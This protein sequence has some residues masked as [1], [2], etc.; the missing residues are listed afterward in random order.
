M[1]KKFFLLISALLTITW[2]ASA[3]QVGVF[4][5]MAATGSQI[6]KDGN[7]MALIKVDKDGTAFLEVENLT[8]RVVFIN[9]ANSF[10]LINRIS[11]PLFI[12]QL[13][14]KSHTNMEGVVV[15]D[16]TFS[17]TKWIQGE[18]HTDSRTMFDSKILAIA[19]H[20]RSMIY[21]WAELPKLLRQDIIQ[22]GKASAMYVKCLGRFLDT[23]KNFHIGDRRDYT[24]EGT[25]LLLAADLE[26]SFTK[27][28]EDSQR[29]YLQDYVKSIQIGNAKCVDDYD[30]LDSG[31]YF[32]FRSGK[33][34]FTSVLEGL[35]VCATVGAIC[36]PFMI[37]HDDMDT[38]IRW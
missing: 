15:D 33:S 35:G 5:R 16:R 2:C 38:D 1:T 25:P 3:R 20:G 27:N 31:P 30:M 32:A 11:E 6:S 29:L 22:V 13:R 7:I 19:P 26:Y 28:G 18:S 23:G 24:L 36:V 21:E 10:S 9:R 34:N 12:P 8:D 17:G 4:C 37:L 14:T